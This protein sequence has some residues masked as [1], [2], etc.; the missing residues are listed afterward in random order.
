MTSQRHPSLRT[1][2]ELFFFFFF[3]TVLS[4][5]DFSY[6]KLGLPFPGKPAATESCYPTYGA[7]LEFSVSI[8]HRTLTSTTG[9][10]TCAQ[11]SMH[12]IAHGG[13]Y[14]HR[15]TV[16]TESGKKNPLPHEG[17]EPVSAACRSDALPTELHPQPDLFNLKKIIYNFHRLTLLPESIQ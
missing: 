4:Q 1:K 11:M 10:L 15:K 12:A 5:W 9:S 17:I 3:R 7:Y 8:I 2:K 14:G 13:L 6:G 16:C